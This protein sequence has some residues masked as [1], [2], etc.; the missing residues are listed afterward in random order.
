[1][2]HYCSLLLVILCLASGPRPGCAAIGES[3]AGP[4]QVQASVSGAV[5]YLETSECYVERVDRCGGIRVVSST[6]GLSLGN[7]V[8]A[9]GTYDVIDGEPCLRD[10]TITPDTG[11][12]ILAPFALSNSSIVGLPAGLRVQDYKRFPLPGGGW[13]YEWVPA[14]GAADIGLL[15]RTWG[16]VRS[17]YHSPTNG[18]RWFYL[19]DGFGA[20]SDL[21]DKGVIVYS[22]ADVKQR[23]VV[24]VTGISSLELSFDSA[25]RLTRVARTRADDDVMVEKPA[26]QPEHPF[27]DEFNGPDLNPGWAFYWDKTMP[28]SV[29]L[30]QEPGSAAITVQTAKA[31]P[32]ERPQLTQYAPGGWVCDIK[33]RCAFVQAPMVNQS[34]G[35]RLAATP[36]VPYVSMEQYSAS[37]KYLLTAGEQW[38]TDHW[39]QMVVYDAHT[40]PMQGDTCYFRIRRAGA[41]HATLYCCVSFDGATYNDEASVGEDSGMQFLTIVP[42]AGDSSGA[43]TPFTA[44]IDYIRFTPVE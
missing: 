20:V 7:L 5:T 14:G 41:V 24:S 6:T 32:Y 2:S 44:F 42:L 21:G 34:I 4:L 38:N 18:A 27:S 23:D 39:E 3:R 9:S 16:I 40:I 35:V 25:E 10:A 11:S 22:D 31:S 29:S 15:A 36:A 8:T 12:A 19:D 37:F 30:T 26:A 33:V 28:A 1:M 17:V 43:G 13:R